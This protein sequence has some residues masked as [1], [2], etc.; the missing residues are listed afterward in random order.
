MGGRDGE[1]RASAG[2]LAAYSQYT[3]RVRAVNDI[4][5]GDWSAASAWARTDADL[6]YEPLGDE[7]SVQGATTRLMLLRF[8]NYTHLL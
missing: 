3:F 2:E 6:S 4:G 1:W 8:R 5:A 7:E